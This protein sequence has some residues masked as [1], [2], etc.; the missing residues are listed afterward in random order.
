[1]IAIFEAQLSAVLQELS[2]QRTLIE[3]LTKRVEAL[4]ERPPR[5]IVFGDNS[6]HSTASN[7]E[8][9]RK[10]GEKIE[11]LTTYNFR[12]FDDFINICK[13]EN[14]E[15]FTQDQIEYESEYYKDFLEEPSKTVLD[16]VTKKSTNLEKICQFFCN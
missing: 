13:E 10:K 15:F 1:L 14:P 2:K 12:A 9:M 11:A 4:K 7:K 6:S 3:T 8:F 16:L 5:S